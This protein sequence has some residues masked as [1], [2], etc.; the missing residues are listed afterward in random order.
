MP[1]P[2]FFFL[3]SLFLFPWGR[4]K[5]QQE[6]EPNANLE[7]P[8]RRDL[9]SLGTF[10]T[11]GAYVLAQQAPTRYAVRQVLDQ[12]LQ[13]TIAMRE[14]AAR[15]A[16]LRYGGGSDIPDDFVF[17]DKT[18]NANR[19]TLLGLVAPSVKKDFF[20]RVISE[21]PEPLG[22]RDANQGARKPRGSAKAEKIFSWV[23]F[24]EGLNNAVTK[25][26]SLRE[27]LSGL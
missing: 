9:E 15:Q 1:F 14:N 11:A 18:V 6:Q 27:L 4:H 7:R 5:Q 22:E 23:T 13:K 21:A 17:E 19:P 12:E 25:P 26:V 16:R 10:E 8:L 2:A 3:F 24:N 20:G